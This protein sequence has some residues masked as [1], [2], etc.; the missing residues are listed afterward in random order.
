MIVRYDDLNAETPAEGGFTIFSTIRSVS[1]ARSQ[2][3]A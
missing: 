2:I 3:F 1:T